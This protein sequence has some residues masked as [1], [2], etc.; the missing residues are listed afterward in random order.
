M[1][2]RSPA[3]ES[4]S[5]KTIELP[6][7]KI[8][9]TLEQFLHW[10]P[11]IG[12]GSGP[13]ID[14]KYAAHSQ[15]KC[16]FANNRARTKKKSFWI[17]IEHLRALFYRRY[18]RLLEEHLIIPFDERAP[19]KQSQHFSKRG[20]SCTRRWLLRSEFWQWPRRSTWILL[21][22][23]NCVIHALLAK[24]ARRKMTSMSSPQPVF[25]IVSNFSWRRSG[26]CRNELFRICR[27]LGTAVLQYGE[28]KGVHS[29]AEIL[30]FL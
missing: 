25:S 7:I 20:I 2:F 8:L 17:E 19:S 15:R 3:P 6:R 22:S 27:C 1:I 11:S 12:D 16:F 5:A 18:Q 21:T 13:K 30:R 4:S 29:S 14:C 28:S 10:Q 9:P 24:P 26:K 23:W